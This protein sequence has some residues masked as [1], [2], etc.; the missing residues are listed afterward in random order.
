MARPL[1]ALLAGGLY[2]VIHRG[3]N[4]QAIFLSDQDRLAFL[5][6][7][8]EY[9]R[10]FRCRLHAYCLMDN[11]LHLLVETR[12]ANLSGFGQRLF[13]SYTLWFNRKHQQVGHLFQGRFKSL[14]VDSDAYLLELSRYIHLN[15]VRARIARK[16]ETYRWSSVRHYAPAGREDG[17]VFTRSVLGY[18]EGDRAR[19][20]QY[21]YEGI[22]KPFELVVTEGVFLGSAE[23]VQKV[24][25]RLGWDD[26]KTNRPEPTGD[27][28]EEIPDAERVVETV[29]RVF[30]VGRSALRR[31][32]VKDKQIVHA[33]QVTAYLLRHHTTLTYRAI[34]SLL[35]GISSPAVANGVRVVATSSALRQR[36]N[37]ALGI[38]NKMKI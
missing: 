17:G 9:A 36:A 26:V 3:N 5:R 7:L 1:R 23:F 37:A 12:L 11:H 10:L 30:G 29:G 18:F 8:A 2:H 25:A 33:R 15:P 28:L 13:G 6:R 38:I 20:M 22:G 24:K 31:K 34:G 27:L 19:Y 32:Y 16:P 35:G 21:V 14:L 4:R